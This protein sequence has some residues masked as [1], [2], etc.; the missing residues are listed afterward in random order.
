MTAKQFIDTNVL[1]Y[2]FDAAAPAKRG[3]AQG[4]LESADPETSV[5]SSQVLNEFFVTVTRKLAR[6][7]EHGPARAVVREM[8]ALDVVPL[9]G[10]LVLRGIDR[11]T[12]SQLSLWDALIVEA[13]LTAGCETLLTEDLSDGQRFDDLLVRD[14]FASLA[15]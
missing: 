10:E 2:A 8:A 11:S 9:T 7:L 3:I 13:A 1:V 14:P 12:A 4:V 6:P 15:D 5:V